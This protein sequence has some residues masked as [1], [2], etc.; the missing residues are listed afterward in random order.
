MEGRETIPDITDCWVRLGPNPSQN[1][2]IL[3]VETPQGDKIVG[4]YRTLDDARAAAN[5]LG[6]EADI[7]DEF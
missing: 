6:W 1:G 5:D 4:G 2:H 3:V 7:R